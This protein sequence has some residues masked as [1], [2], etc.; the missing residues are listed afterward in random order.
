MQ[1]PQGDLK[2]QSA[3]S[4][5]GKQPGRMQQFNELFVD[6]KKFNDQFSLG[7]MLGKS[8]IDNLRIE[9]NKEPSDGLNLSKVGGEELQQMTASGINL[10]HKPILDATGLSI[11]PV[12]GKNA[13]IFSA[14]EQIG[15]GEIRINV[16]QGSKFTSF[17]KSLDGQNVNLE[18][19]NNLKSLSYILSKQVSDNY[20]LQRPSDEALQLLVSLGNIVKEYRRLDIRGFGVDRLEAY[21]KHSKQRDLREYLV[22]EQQGLFAE[23]GKNFG[24][25]DWETDATPEYLQGR[26]N[27]ALKAL[28]MTEGNPNA[29]ELYHKL[30]SHLEM[31][32]GMAITRLETLNYL[33]PERKSELRN[34]LNGVK[35]AFG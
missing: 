8:L 2:P 31:C 15:E 30:F 28:H 35:Q 26:W 16:S 20:D 21:L 19:K 33:T 12:S 24:P 18:F 10:M 29:R 4:E 25:A 17:L 11:E 32:L 6:I 14:G 3:S 34:V 13:K 23:P 22:I 9:P 1:E 5:S 27:N 7:T